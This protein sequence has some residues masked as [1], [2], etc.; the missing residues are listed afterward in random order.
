MV[1]NLIREFA[2]VKGLA[3]HSR[4]PLAGIQLLFF[5]VAPLVAKMRNA[6]HSAG[7]PTKTLGDDGFGSDARASVLADGSVT[8]LD[9]AGGR[10]AT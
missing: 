1:S 2:I 10:S 9:V 5:L 3:R 6:R 4:M 7:S 8:F